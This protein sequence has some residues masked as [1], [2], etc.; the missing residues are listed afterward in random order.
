MPTVQFRDSEIQC[1]RGA[2]LRDVLLAAGESP[3]NGSADMLNCRGRGT[4]G[5]CAVAVEGAVT[6]RTKREETRLSFPPHHPDSGL[7]LSC[8]TRVLGDVTVEKHPGFW[9]Q[10]VEESERSEDNGTGGGDE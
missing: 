1:E 2:V 7:R 10:H 4:C 5:T 8:Q 6:D 3:H 9:G